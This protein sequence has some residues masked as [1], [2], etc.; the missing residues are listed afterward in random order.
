M[1][2]QIRVTATWRLVNRCTG[3]TPGKLFQMATSFAAGHFPAACANSCWFVNISV[4]PSLSSICSEAN[5]VMLFS[6][7]IRNVVI[8][9]SLGVLAIDDIHGSYRPHR[10]VISSEIERER[11]LIEAV[12]LGRVH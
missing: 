8:T 3:S 11:V 5:A 10:Q 12:D 7:S 2:F 4:S 1:A 9:S 6:A